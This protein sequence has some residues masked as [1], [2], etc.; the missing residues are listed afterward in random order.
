MPCRSTKRTSPPCRIA[1]LA[2]DIYAWLAQRLH[3]IP[4][5]K[6]ARISWA[7]LHGQFGQGYNP[8]HIDKFRQVFRVALKEVLTLYKSRP[9]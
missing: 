9:C 2:L 8:E 3:R 5:G 1:A 4:A 6:P 7:A